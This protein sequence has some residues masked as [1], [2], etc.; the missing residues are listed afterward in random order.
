MIAWNYIGYLAAWRAVVRMLRGSND[1]TKTSRSREPSEAA[2]KY[3]P[4]PRGTWQQN[5]PRPT[6]RPHPGQH[7]VIPEAAAVHSA[8]AATMPRHGVARP[9]AGRGPT[10]AFAEPK[11]W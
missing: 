11:R 1:W 3:V 5:R 4:E 8:V 9:R 10:A 6:N 2:A 7:R